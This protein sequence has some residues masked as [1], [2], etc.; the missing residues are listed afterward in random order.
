MALPVHDWKQR[1]KVHLN[2]PALPSASP[3]PATQ[4]AAWKQELRQHLRGADAGPAAAAL[5]TMHH[6]PP[7]LHRIKRPA[8]PTVP[9]GIEDDSMS[10]REDSSNDSGGEWDQACF[11]SPRPLSGTQ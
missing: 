7:S 5:P 11:L 2:D 4:N 9:T 10:S 6:I 1:L 8:Q 3:A